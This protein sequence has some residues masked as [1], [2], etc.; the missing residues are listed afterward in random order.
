MT[1]RPPQSLGS[2]N[3]GGT[4]DPV[5]P[6]Q[7][8]RTRMMD[9]GGFS[10][11]AAPTAAALARRRVAVRLAK[12]MLPAC[13]AILLASIALWPELARLSDQERVTF[14]RLSTSSVGGARVTDA[15]YHGVDEH[16]RPYTLTAQTA[17]QINDDRIDLVTPAGDALSESGSWMMLRA[18]QGVYQPHGGLLD[19]S[20]EVAVYR[21][22]G[23]V[24]H[25]DVATVDLKQGAAVANAQVHAEG[26]FG[27][28]D[29]QAYAITDKGAV[30]QFTGPAKLVLNGD[31]S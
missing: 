10:R 8:R 16:G 28:L 15:R 20:G 2:Q 19:L 11:R 21:D 5:R 18:Q 26:P 12:I 27:T 22:D 1:Q 3:L 25:S 4:Q 29:A 30:V 24:L 14:R 13:A 9:G 23:T 6:I 31:G 7:P 17:T